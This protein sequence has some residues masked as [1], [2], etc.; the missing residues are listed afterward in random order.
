MINLNIHHKH[1]YL[2]DNLNIFLR[3][4]HKVNPNEIY[5]ATVDELLKDYGFILIYEA[6]TGYYEKD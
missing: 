5:L 1:N 3:K 4:T 2:F 6:A